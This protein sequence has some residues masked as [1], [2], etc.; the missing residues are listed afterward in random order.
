MVLQGNRTDLLGHL[1]S[2]A[3]FGLL[4][5][6]AG[7]DRKGRKVLTRQRLERF[8]N[9]SLFYQLADEVAVRRAGAGASLFMAVRNSLEELY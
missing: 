2:M 1:G 3:E 7:E 6:L 5:Y 8:Y 4:L 9:G